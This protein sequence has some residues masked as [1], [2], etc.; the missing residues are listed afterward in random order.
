VVLEGMTGV[1]YHPSHVWKLLTQLGWT[2]QRPGKRAREC[3]Q[4]AIEHWR[5]V[6]WPRIVRNAK[7]RNAIICF[8]DEAGISLKP[9]VRATWAPKGKTPVLVHPCSWGRLSMAAVLGYEPDRSDAWVVFQVM[10]GSYNSEGL[11][12]F[13]D[14]LKGHLD[15]R[16]ITMI[17]DNLPSHRSRA[18][19]EWANTQRDWLVIERLP[20]YAPKLNPVELLWAWAKSQELANLCVGTIEEVEEVANTTLNRAGDEVSRLIGFLDH[21]VP[22]W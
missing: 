7:R 16:K 8:E 12:A 3:D 6:E 19:K 5:E 14:D 21:C 22:G 1:A 17:W 20:G 10:A 18:F 9:P 15:G 11:V 4:A 13:M 2:K